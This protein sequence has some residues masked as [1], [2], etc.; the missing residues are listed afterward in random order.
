MEG[1]Q[2]PLEDS[3]AAYKRGTELLAV[4]PARAQGREQQV[5]VLEE[6]ELQAVRAGTV[7]RRR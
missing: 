2:L 3:L 1:G 5:K 7:E 4:L 6:G